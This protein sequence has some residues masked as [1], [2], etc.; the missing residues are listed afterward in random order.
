EIVRRLFGVAELAAKLSEGRRIVV[1]AVDVAQLGD[2]LG[3]R[4]VVR[5]PVRRDALF[6]ARNQ[7]LECPSRLRHADDWKLEP[8]APSERMKSWKDLLVGKVSACTEEH[9]RIGARSGHR[10][11]GTAFREVRHWGRGYR[12]SSA[13]ALLSCSAA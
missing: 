8:S 4:R 10:K 5:A 6:G 12:R 11:V 7:L 1:V 13:P 9:E 3:E 2:E